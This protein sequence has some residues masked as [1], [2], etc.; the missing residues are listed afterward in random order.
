VSTGKVKVA[1]L[2]GLLL[3]NDKDTTTTTVAQFWG[4]NNSS[5]SDSHFRIYPYLG[6][7]GTVC[8]SE[9]FGLNVAVAVPTTPKYTTTSLS[10]VWII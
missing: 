8:F 2:L 6:V 1:P 10:F 7:S 5:S 4:D 9:H 3:L